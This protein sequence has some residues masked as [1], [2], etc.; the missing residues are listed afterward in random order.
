VGFDLDDMQALELWRRTLLAGVHRATPDLSVRQMAILLCVYLTAPPH[1]VRGLAARL[2]ISKPAV[3]RALDSLSGLGVLRRK[4]DEKDR[5]SVLVHRT[6]A[7][8]VYL[9]EFADTIVAAGHELGSEKNPV[10]DPGVLA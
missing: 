7:G 1:T 6:V 10:S 5:R 9:S 4:T 8:S 3:T 2:K